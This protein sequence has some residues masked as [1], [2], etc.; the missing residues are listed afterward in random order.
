MPFYFFV[1]VSSFG[2]I[3]IHFLKWSYV[4]NLQSHQWSLFA[5]WSSF[6]PWWGSWMWTW[7][8]S[9]TEFTRSW[10]IWRRDTTWRWH[11][12]RD[13]RSECWIN[14]INERRVCVRVAPCSRF[15][16]SEPLYPFSSSE[17][18]YVDGWMDYWVGVCRDI[19]YSRIQYK[20][21]TNNI[22]L[23]F[24]HFR[25]CVNIFSADSVK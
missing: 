6:C 23:L 4:V 2:D 14:Y 24:S 16:W 20:H 5:V 19:I 25:T 9:V 21:F 18:E 15:G 13:L 8:P 12:I 10:P 11:S 7:T 17:I 22:L 1:C 3:H